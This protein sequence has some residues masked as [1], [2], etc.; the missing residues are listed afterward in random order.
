MTTNARVDLWHRRLEHPE[1]TM[2]RRMILLLTGHEMCRACLRMPNMHPKKIDQT[3][4]DLET[5]RGH[6]CIIV[7]SSRWLVWLNKLYTSQ[8]KYN[9]FLIDASWRH[10][11]VFLLTTRTMVFSKTLAMQ[12]KFRKQYHDHPHWFLRMYNVLEFKSQAFEY[13]CSTIGIEL[14][15]FAPYEHS[16]NNLAEVFIKKIQLIV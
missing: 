2:M 3:T 15:Y 9:I 10:V 14:T 8:F 16:Q 13:Y 11:E 6:A 4:F 12:L 7:L 1:I 5:T